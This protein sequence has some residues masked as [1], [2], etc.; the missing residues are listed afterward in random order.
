ME[1]RIVLIK[2]TYR[3]ILH[4]YKELTIIKYRIKYIPN[5]TG[6]KNVIETYHKIYSNAKIIQY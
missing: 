2:I 3:L 6:T 1:I 4:I 5:G